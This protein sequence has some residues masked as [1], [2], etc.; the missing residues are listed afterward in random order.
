[1]ALYLIAHVCFR[2]R[3][4]HSVNKQRVLVAGLLVV[5][6]PVAA[7]LPALVA[8]GVLAALLIGLIAYEAIRFAESRDS[9][10]HAAHD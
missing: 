1:V 7:H 8:V 5:L 9:I 2:L 10:R 6:L 4:I 3:N